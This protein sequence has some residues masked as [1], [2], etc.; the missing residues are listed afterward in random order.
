MGLLVFMWQ[1]IYIGYLLT[2]YKNN[3]IIEVFVCLL[4]VC[5]FYLF[6]CLLIKKRNLL[7]SKSHVTI[8]SLGKNYMV[9]CTFLLASKHLQVGTIKT[10][11][12]IENNTCKQ[13][14]PGTLQSC[15]SQIWASYDFW[16]EKFRFFWS[17]DKQINKTNKQTVNK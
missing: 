10:S 15:P 13:Y 7:K 2:T 12:I 1:L 4:T 11:S 3:I 14:T 9:G 17:V 16:T 6:L 5:L 8:S